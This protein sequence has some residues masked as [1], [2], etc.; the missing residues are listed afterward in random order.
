[1]IQINFFT[2]FAFFSEMLKNLVHITILVMTF[3]S[4]SGAGYERLI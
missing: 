3:I 1:M 4:N 2:L